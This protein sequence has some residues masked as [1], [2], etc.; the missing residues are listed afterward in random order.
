[1]RN[2]RHIF[3]ISPDLPKDCRAEFAAVG[4]LGYFM[5]RWEDRLADFHV[6]I[7]SGDIWGQFIQASIQA[8]WG[9]QDAC[10]ALE[11]DMAENP[12]TANLKTDLS[13]LPCFIPRGSEP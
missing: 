8:D 12:W 2:L 3:W 6:E 4:L 7:R 13:V 1:M 11:M 10:Y 9:L 5:G